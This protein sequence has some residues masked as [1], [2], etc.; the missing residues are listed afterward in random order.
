[1]GHLIIDTESLG[2]SAGTLPTYI[3]FAKQSHAGAESAPIGPGYSRASGFDQLGTIHGLSM[4]GAPGS[5][6]EV[7]GQLDIEIEN[8]R[9]N[10]GATRGVMMMQDAAAALAF[11]VADMGGAVNQVTESFTARYT[12]GASPLHKAPVVVVPD[13]T[14]STLLGKLQMSDAG[15]ATTSQSIWSQ[16]AELTG[17]ISEGMWEVANYILGQNQGATPEAIASRLQNV[18]TRTGHISGNS[19]VFATSLGG[20]EAARAQNTTMVSAVQAQLDLMRASGPK[21]VAAAE[22]VEKAFLGYYTAATQGMLTGLIPPVVNLTLP[23]RANP[24]GDAVAGMSD[25]DGTGTRYSP[26][27]MLAP[28]SVLDDVAEARRMFPG[29]VDVVNQVTRNMADNVG[30][31]IGEGLLSPSGVSTHSASLGAPVSPMGQMA[32]MTPS[33]LGAGGLGGLGGLNTGA[34]GL[35]GLTPGGLAA[36]AGAGT[37]LLPGGLNGGAG[38]Q[39]PAAALAGGLPAGTNGAAGRGIGTGGSAP[40]GAAAATPGT[41]GSAGALGGAGMM[42]GRGASALGATPGAGTAATGSGTSNAHA[43]AGA[44]L[45]GGGMRAGGI[46]GFGGAGGTGAFGGAGG[47]SGTGTLGSSSSSD[48]DNARKPGAAGTSGNAPATHTT[49]ANGAR[50]QAGGAGAAGPMM[51]GAGRGGAANSERKRGGAVRTVTS[52]IER[53]GDMRDLLGEPR[54]VVAGVIGDWVRDEPNTP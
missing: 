49:S 42:P 33:A 51:G 27:G 32:G 53:E 24:G 54:P 18:G 11:D 15:A 13:P 46:G 12:S 23:D 39:G 47:A 30:A 34:A 35:S 48:A 37:G 19:T 8:V 5:A 29:A 3:R 9:M 25:V 14:V 2:T 21:G 7:L 28:V 44:A 6:G 40:L 50:A 31:D 1:M 45:P 22:V 38:M 4:S 20:L 10:L 17:N 52:A 36:G 41:A 26:D 43:R 16:I